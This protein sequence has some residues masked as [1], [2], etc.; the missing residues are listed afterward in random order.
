MLAVVVWAI[1]IQ[2]GR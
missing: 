1:R 2:N